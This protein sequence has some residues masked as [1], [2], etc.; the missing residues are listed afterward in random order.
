MLELLTHQKLSADFTFTTILDNVNCKFRIMW[1]SKTQFWM[2]NTYEEPDNEF[3][4]H[5]L[6]IIP[7][8]PFLHRYNP[9]LSGEMI[10]LNKSTD[11]E[12]HITYSNFGEGWGLFYIN[13][14]EFEIWSDLNGF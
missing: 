9:S 11:V 7:N 13:S 12:N 4:L 3:I 8:Y 2:I 6:K 10:C 1:N 14:D 5:G